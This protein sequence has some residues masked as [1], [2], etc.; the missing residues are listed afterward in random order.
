MSNESLKGRILEAVKQAMRAGE[1]QRLGTLRL[2]T[3]AIK[4]R[5]VDE[6]IEL[7]DDDVVALLS[8]QV[9]QRQES[10]A[11]YEQASRSDLAEKEQAEIV[12]IQEFLPQPLSDDEINA[13]IEEALQE[14][15]ADSVR[16]MGKVMAV[17]RPKLQGR[18]DMG[19]ASGRVKQRLS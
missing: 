2:L 14:T 17:L 10:I 8:K 7:S 11:Q 4:Q 3:A 18:A 16:D 15:G 6:R 9:K 1:K 5:E 12:I 13:L 19:A